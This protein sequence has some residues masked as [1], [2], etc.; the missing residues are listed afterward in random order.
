[1]GHTWKP[2]HVD[3]MIGMVVYY[4]S[5]SAVKYWVTKKIGSVVNKRT[6]MVINYRVYYKRCVV[7]NNRYGSL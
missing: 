5:G 4:R 1:M 2:T 7:D 6:S 3:L